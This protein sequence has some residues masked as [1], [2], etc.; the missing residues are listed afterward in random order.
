MN[1]IVG[2]V[3]INGHDYTQYVKAKTGLSW[4][5]NN[6]NDTD[7]GRDASDTM[8]PMVT[9]HQ[10]TLGFKMGPMPF[11]VAQQLEQDLEGNDDGVLVKYPDLRDG[12]CTRLFYNSAIKAAME[13]F[14]PDGI[15]VDDIN[16]TLITVKEDTYA[17]GSD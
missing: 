14:T 15:L 3:E 12:I 17:D 6:T 1:A 9:S 16:F 13:Q 7:A 11:S 2:T 4:E 8:H 5:R 10:R